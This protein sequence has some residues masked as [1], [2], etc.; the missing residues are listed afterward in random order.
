MGRFYKELL[1]KIHDSTTNSLD[2]DTGS[3]TTRRLWLRHKQLKADSA[4]AAAASFTAPAGTAPYKRHGV[5]P[6]RGR[7]ADTFRGLTR[8]KPP[9]AAQDL[10]AS[11]TQYQAVTHLTSGINGFL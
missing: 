8:T 4:G 5:Y 1:R 6:A 7:T 9:T 10:S 2:A 3:A 11:D